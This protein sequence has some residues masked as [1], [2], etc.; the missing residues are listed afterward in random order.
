[1]AHFLALLNCDTGETTPDRNF[2]VRK[3]TIWLR[4]IKKSILAVQRS[5]S[6]NS[7]IN[8]NAASPGPDLK[9]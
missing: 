7:N 1:M 3:S 8:K 9:R 6:A 2:H 5:V 4:L